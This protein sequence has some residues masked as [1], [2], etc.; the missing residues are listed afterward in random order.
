M[1]DPK[2]IKVIERFYQALDMA[3]SSKKIRGI[4]TFTD[5]HGIDR[6]ALYKVRKNPAS[7]AFQMSWLSYIISDFKISAKWLMSGEGG[8]LEQ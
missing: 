4:K 7:D 2:S 8:M 1:N 3:V 5:I 6:R